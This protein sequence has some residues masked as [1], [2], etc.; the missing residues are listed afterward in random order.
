MAIKKQVRA[1]SHRVHPGLGLGHDDIGLARLKPQSRPLFRLP[2]HACE[3]QQVL[4]R[5]L[6][7]FW[8]WVGFV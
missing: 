2:G 6:P 7:F 8:L 3:E 4:L 1:A 5:Q